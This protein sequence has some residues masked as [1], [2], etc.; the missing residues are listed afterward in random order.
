MVRIS[1]F[2]LCIALLLVSTAVA[3]RDSGVGAAIDE[4]CAEKQA[5]EKSAT[6]RATR[7]RVPARETKAK[8][9]SNGDLPSGRLQSPR[10]HSFLPGMFR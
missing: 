3:A 10:W 8:S 5:A 4:T 7:N 2:V 1:V 6:A 9:T